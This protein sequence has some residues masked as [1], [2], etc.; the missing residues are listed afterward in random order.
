MIVNKSSQN[1]VAS[2]SNGRSSTISHQN[3]NASPESSP[4]RMTDSKQF[5]LFLEKKR[6]SMNI[7]HRRSSDINFV[8]QIH[9]ETRNT[10]SP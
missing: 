2:G 1:Y 5:K 10:L 9:C 3:S 6:T 8:T 7:D 4:S